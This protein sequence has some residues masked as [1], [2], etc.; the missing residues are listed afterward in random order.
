MPATDMHFGAKPELFERA[1]RMRNNPTP[2]EEL[3]W[4]QVSKKQLGVKFRNQ[5][6][7]LFFIADFYCHE[8]RLVVEIDGGY[9]K[10]REQYEY[11]ENRTAEIETCEIAVIRFTN[12]Q[13]ENHLPAVLLQLKEL[14]SIRKTNFPIP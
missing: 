3:F 6:P 1:R 2:A 14:I 10:K 12:A 8:L 11:D 4:Q 9:H 7:L 13:I 5:H